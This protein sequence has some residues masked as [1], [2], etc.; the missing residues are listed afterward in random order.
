[1]G[2]TRSWYFN[3]N[4]YREKHAR[5]AEHNILW[6]RKVATV[7]T[8]EVKFFTE[9]MILIIIRRGYSGERETGRID[10]GRGEGGSCGG[11]RHARGGG[12]DEKRHRR[13]C[14]TLV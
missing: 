8:T 12:F 11:G 13:Y 3:T 1:M 7:I 10:G 5:V 4:K 6:T 9:K 14:Y 2:E